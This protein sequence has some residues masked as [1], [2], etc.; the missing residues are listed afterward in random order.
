MKM[1]VLGIDL[2]KNVFQRFCQISRQ[3]G[4]LGWDVKPSPPRVASKNRGL[5][6][7]ENTVLTLLARNLTESSGT[8]IRRTAPISRSV[9]SNT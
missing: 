7:E 4:F 5:C 9:R 8:T 1:T 3:T 6:V 2:A